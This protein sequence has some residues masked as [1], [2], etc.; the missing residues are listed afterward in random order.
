MKHQQ[1]FP[2]YSY[3]KIARKSFEKGADGFFG[4]EGL[5][6]RFGGENKIK[7]YKASVQNVEVCLK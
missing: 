4:N 5:A 3:H 7:P 1:R 2:I 6:G